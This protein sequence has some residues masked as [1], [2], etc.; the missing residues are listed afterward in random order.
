MGNMGYQLLND[1]GINV[2]TP[3]PEEA[4]EL[5]G[6]VWDLQPSGVHAVDTGANPTE[7][8]LPM[9]GLPV[10]HATCSVM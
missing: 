6:D 4:G 2:T 9:D 1:V 3:P 7:E 5:A 10:K 8:P